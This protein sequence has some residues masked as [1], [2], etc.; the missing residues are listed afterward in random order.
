MM[1]RELRSW[2]DTTGTL[3]LLDEVMTGFG[4]TGC[5]FACQREAVIPDLIALAKGA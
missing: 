4:R 5:M 3:L 2:C 1:L